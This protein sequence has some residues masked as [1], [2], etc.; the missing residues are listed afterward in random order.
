MEPI[1]KQF[2]FLPHPSLHIVAHAKAAGNW[3]DNSVTPLPG[4]LVFYNWSGGNAA[5]DE[6]PV[7]LAEG[8]WRKVRQGGLKGAIQVEFGESS[9]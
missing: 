4:W 6:P 7:E 5:D 2:Y 3:V 8:A 9:T 1:I